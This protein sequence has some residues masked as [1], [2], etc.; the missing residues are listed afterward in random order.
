[1]NYIEDAEQY[2]WDYV[3]RCGVDTEEISDTGTLS[4]LMNDGW[5]PTE[6]TEGKADRFIM[7]NICWL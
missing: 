2:V 7:D 6:I 4:N 5:T 3:A 1:M